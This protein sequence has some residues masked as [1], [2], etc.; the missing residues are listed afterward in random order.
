MRTWPIALAF[1]SVLIL[2]GVGILPGVITG[3]NRFTTTN[4]NTAYLQTTSTYDI[5]YKFGLFSPPV[6]FQ[7]PALANTIGAGPVVP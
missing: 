4:L 3:Y 7:A 2:L 1:F 6:S 5:P